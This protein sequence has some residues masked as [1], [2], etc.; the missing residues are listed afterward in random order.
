[1]AYQQNQGDREFLSVVAWTGPEGKRRALD[2]GY[3][4]TGKSGHVEIVVRS[5]PVNWDGKATVKPREQRGQG[6]QG[7]GSY[8]GG[9]QRPA[10][11]PAARPA[12]DE[13]VPY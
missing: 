9:Q 4:Y 3:A 5:I 1:M 2:I 8:Q 6:G 13:D 10:T 11:A 7:G 12:Q